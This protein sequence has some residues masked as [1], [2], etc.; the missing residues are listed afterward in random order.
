M[1]ATPSTMKLDLGTPAP[2]FALPD[3]VTGLTVSLAD[4]Q[5]RAGLLV[6]FLCNHCPYV[7]LVRGQ[8]AKIV[9]EYGPLGLAAV[10]I[11]SNDVASYPEDSPTHMRELAQSEGWTF[12]FLY[13]AT[14]E[15]ARAYHAACTPDFFVFDA[16]RRLAYRGQLDDAR[17]GKGVPVTGRDLRRAL[18]AVLA[19]EPAPADQRP[20][21]G[22][23]I[24]W[25][26]GNEPEQRG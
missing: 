15:V 9:A 16:D 10:A 21:I 24:K 19:G 5:G 12:P 25:L 1:T 23:S 11:N 8:V 20:S 14:Q 18:D 4:L 22:C 2:D 3:A 7:K 26:P 6:M 17:P 13:D